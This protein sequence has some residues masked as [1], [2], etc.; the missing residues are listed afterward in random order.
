MF[1]LKNINNYIGIRISGITQKNHPDW[2]ITQTTT[3]SEIL[4]TL[5]YSDSIKDKP[6]YFPNPILLRKL[7]TISN[8]LKINFFPG[9]GRQ[10][11]RNLG[12]DMIPKSRY[13]R[14]MIFDHLGLIHQYYLKQQH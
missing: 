10:E 6:K 2:K 14:G 8:S 12:I 13:T 5:Y 3:A 4:D 1:I 7:S 11:L 9:I